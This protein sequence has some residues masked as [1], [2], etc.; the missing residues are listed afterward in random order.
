MAG[1]VPGVAGAWEPA[2][3]GRGR[4]KRWCDE[5][6]GWPKSSS[7]ADYARANNSAFEEVEGEMHNETAWGGHL[8]ARVLRFL[9][10]NDNQPKRPVM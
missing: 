7:T 9:F 5:C 3:G 10:G 1:A 4:R 2:E 6:A 8:D